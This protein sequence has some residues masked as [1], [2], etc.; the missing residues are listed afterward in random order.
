[1][2]RTKI[3]DRVTDEVAAKKALPEPTVEEKVAKAE[4]RASG[5]RILRNHSKR[6]YQQTKPLKALHFKVFAP[7][8]KKHKDLTLH[9]PPK[10]AIKPGG[11]QEYIDKVVEQ[12]E[13]EFPGHEYH[14]VDL[15]KG[16]FNFVHVSYPPVG[17]IPPVKEVPVPAV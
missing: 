1:M 8:N 9:C 14:F 11:E 15:G 16:H 7:G 17:F 3:L 5:Q 6:L 13:T 10:Y 2:E 4:V 12:I